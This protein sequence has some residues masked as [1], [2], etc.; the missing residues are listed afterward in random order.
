MAKYTY[1]RVKLDRDGRT[2]WINGQRDNGGG[3]Q[4]LNPIRLSVDTSSS[5][6]LGLSPSNWRRVIA[7][8]GNAT[9]PLS[10]Y[11]RTIKC[12]PGSW[13]YHWEPFKAPNLYYGSGDGPFLLSFIGG[14]PQ[15]PSDDIDSSADQIARR[16]FLSKYLE[17]R[18]NWRGGNFIAEFRDTVHMLRHPISG[19]FDHTM[20]FANKVARI[21]NLW[22]H[23]RH[24]YAQRLGQLW[25]SYSFGWKPFFEDI[26]D[27]NLA[28]S[29]LGNKHDVIRIKGYGKHESYSCVPGI[30]VTPP[31]AI[32][33]RTWLADR[34]DIQRREVRYTGALLARP[35]VY[36]QILDDF[37]IAPADILPAV[38]EAIPW[39]FFVDYF[40][41]VGEMLDSM[42]YAQADFAWVNVG[43]KNT[44]FRQITGLRPASNNP[45]VGY[46]NEVS[47][48][49]AEASATRVKRG[50]SSVPYP[51]FRFQI[52]GLGSAKWL[53]IAALRAAISRSKP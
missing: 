51:S 35:T 38:W 52:P 25:L 30:T 28:I 12:A 6:T 18:G 11:R 46:V 23:A 42:H 41:N 1:P 3:L 10:G 49:G 29:A 21:K 47:C 37:G 44:N 16:K 26:Q 50:Q 24:A 4:V 13:N 48:N 40:V 19:L 43:V 20:A 22:R 32:A 5:V 53:N 8:G 31:I 45:K 33:G 39:S 9:S 34:V 15:L 14:V 27:L 7:N 2:Y 36:G 17:K